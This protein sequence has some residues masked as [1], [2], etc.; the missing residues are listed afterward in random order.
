MNAFTYISLGPQTRGQI[1]QMFYDGTILNS[2]GC[3]GHRTEAFILFRKITQGYGAALI[4]NSDQDFLRTKYT[5]PILSPTK[6]EG[7]DY[8]DIL[9]C[10]IVC[11][12]SNRGRRELT[13]KS[14]IPKKSV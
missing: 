2:D 13:T 10:L 7:N 14:Y 4:Q 12:V 8:A 3:R 6:K 11:M 5:T 9:L 1:V